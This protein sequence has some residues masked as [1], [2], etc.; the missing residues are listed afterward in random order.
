[1]KNWVGFRARQGHGRMVLGAMLAVTLAACGGSGSS[2]SNTQVANSFISASTVLGHT[3]FSSYKPNQTASG[4]TI[5]VGPVG[6]NSPIGSVA[7]NGTLFYVA[8]T[9][10]NRILGY[11]SVP[12]SNGQ[13]ADFVIGQADLTANNPATSATGLAFP[14]KVSVSDD[15]THLVVTDSGNNRVLI[16]NSLPTSNVQADVVIG[17]TDF[18]SG[19]P[20]QSPTATGPTASSLSNPT[21]A[22]IANGRLF[23]VDNN[24]NRLLIWNS[25]PTVSGQDA[26]VVWGQP[27]FTTNTVN[28]GQG[29]NNG[30][31]YDCSNSSYPI[32]AYSL[33]QPLDLWTNGY[34]LLVADSSNNR[35]L[36]WQQIPTSNAVAA[37]YPMGQGTFSSGATG[38]TS[39]SGMNNPYS[40]ASD[41]A[42]VFVADNANNRVLVFS[43]FPKQAA[44]KALT[45]LGQNYWTTK[46]ANDDNQDGTQDG[47]PSARTLNSPTGVY[48]VVNGSTGNTDVYVTDSG[49][50][51]ILKFNPSLQ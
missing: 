33:N 47:G 38:S 18:T 41:G 13:A 4:A 46:T 40:V 39:Q 14:Y 43:G 2:S 36:Y 26:D 15:G 5:G 51:R 31:T 28:C 25:I 23:V 27:S 24:N 48:A 3:D 6:L 12:T 22:M 16:W 10:N 37:N 44:P 42:F 49:N 20:N 21:A 7:T 35:V 29:T 19:Y 34:Q 50:N 1:M 32:S 45:V 8:D 30:G 11:N 9:F 17:Q